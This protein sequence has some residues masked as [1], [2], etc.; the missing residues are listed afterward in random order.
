MPFD[1]NNAGATYQHFMI[2]I[3]DDYI[4]EIVE[5]YVEDLFSKY[6]N[7]EIHFE[8]LENIFY[9]LIKHNVK[10]NPK[11]YVFGATYGKLLGY[12]ISRRGIK[13]YPAKIKSIIEMNPPQNIK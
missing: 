6:K 7:K 11:N 4:G 2:Y 13:V 12:I 3:F 8:I 5:W 9:K 1:L 10:L